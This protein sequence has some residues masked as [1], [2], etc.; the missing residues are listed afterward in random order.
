V[1]CL[2]DV[3]LLV[4]WGWTDHADHSRVGKWLAAERGV[5]GTQLMTSAIPELGFVRVSIQRSRGRVT[6]VQAS[7]VLTSMIQSLGAAH[8]FLA[9]DEP[10]RAWPAWCNGAPQTTDAH[11]LRLAEAHGAILATLDQG[12]P[13]AFLVP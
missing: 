7:A 8:R 9:D 13:G 11:L 12:I 3:N 1:N 4:A 5:A 2:L 10:S 6:P